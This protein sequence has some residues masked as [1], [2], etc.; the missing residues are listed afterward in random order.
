MRHRGKPC[1]HHRS[2]SHEI[3]LYPVTECNG[4]R[5]VEIFLDVHGVIARL[6]AENLFGPRKCAL[7]FVCKWLPIIVS[8]Q[9]ACLSR[10]VNSAGECHPHTVEAVG[11]NP[12]P[13]TSKTNKLGDS[14][15]SPSSFPLKGPRHAL[16]LSRRAS[17]SLP[18]VQ[19]RLNV[20][21]SPAFYPPLSFNM[22]YEF[23]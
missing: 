1:I 9:V 19:D 12:T 11:S 6:P 15:E 13:P 3:T 7:L 4:Q 8:I 23:C 10:A 18:A 21:L 20:V 16:P 5:A 2:L 17:C 22:I 14:N